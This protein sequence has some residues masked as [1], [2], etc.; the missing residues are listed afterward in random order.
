MGWA[1]SR[2]ESGR[3]GSESWERTVANSVFSLKIRVPINLCD[4]D[5]SDTSCREH[6]LVRASR[7]VRGRN[8]TDGGGRAYLFGKNREGLRCLRL[9]FEEGS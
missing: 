6:C 1:E 7:N 3:S 9:I 2:L 4:Y 5:V 8:D